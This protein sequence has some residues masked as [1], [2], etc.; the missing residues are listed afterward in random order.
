MAK[1]LEEKIDAVEEQT[2]TQTEEAPEVKNYDNSAITSSAVMNMG[3][4]SDDEVKADL[5]EFVE[6]LKP[7]TSVLVRKSSD[8]DMS[9]IGRDGKQVI[10]ICPLKKA[11]SA[12]LPGDSGIL[13]H[14]KK[15]ILK[16]IQ[17]LE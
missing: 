8:H 2:K 13:R 10:K 5:E 17:D 3:Y 1:K 9:V 16:A 12:Y 11:Y 14:R 15:T 6:A 7:K 4:V